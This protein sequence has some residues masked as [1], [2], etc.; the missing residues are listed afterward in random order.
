M[1]LHTIPSPWMFCVGLCL[2]LTFSLRSISREYPIPLSENKIRQKCRSLQRLSLICV[3]FCPLCR[4]LFW[5]RLRKALTRSLRSAD[6]QIPSACLSMSISTSSSPSLASLRK[7]AA[8]SRSTTAGQTGSLLSACM[9][10]SSSE[11]R[12]KSSTSSF[13]TRLWCRITTACCRCS[14][15]RSPLKRASA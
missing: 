8:T 15:F 3:A 12:F 4:R 10:Y 14:S 9:E 13:I 11:V 7:A 1:I 5:N 6:T 2:F